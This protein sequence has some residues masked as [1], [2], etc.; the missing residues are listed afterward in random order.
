MNGGLQYAPPAISAQII[1]L[2]FDGAQTAYKG[3]ILTLDT[4]EVQDSLLTAERINNIVTALNE[5]Y[6]SQNVVFVAEKPKSAEYS[7]IFIGKTTAFDQYGHFTGLAE[8]I[9]EGN[10]NKSDNAF[11]TLDTSAT[12]T[13]IIATIAHETDHLLGTLDHGGK[14]IA[15]EETRKGRDREHEHLREE[16]HRHPRKAGY[17]WPGEPGRICRYPE[18]SAQPQWKPYQT[19]WLSPH[20]RK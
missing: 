12:D 10:L 13:Q 6:A 19:F 2:D 14:G 15:G 5:K 18:P 17:P 16:I 1:Y 9:D 8:T 11:V 20:P 7:T 4:V 3:E